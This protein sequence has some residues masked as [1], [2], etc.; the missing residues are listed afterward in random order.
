MDR[1]GAS[2]DGLSEASG[3]TWLEARCDSEPGSGYDAAGWPASTWV[4]HAMYESPVTSSE[5]HQDRREGLISAGLVEPQILVGVNMDEESI[6]TGGRLGRS[7]RP[8]G[9]WQRLTWHAL[10]DRLEVDLGRSEYPPCHR[11]FPYGSWPSRIQPPCEGSL[12]LESFDALIDCLS[13]HSARGLATR[14]RAFSVPAQWFGHQSGSL[15]DAPL[16][17]I[18]TFGSSVRQVFTPTNFWPDD[19]SWLVYTDYDL[20][21]TKVSGSHKLISTIVAHPLLETI[22]WK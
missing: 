2:G 11:W 22:D 10:A 1:Q 9:D 4:L 18:P 21:A 17:S 5:S 13:A 12:D 8:E 14:C 19:R 7:Q 16:G 20:W 6:V 3:L 15:L